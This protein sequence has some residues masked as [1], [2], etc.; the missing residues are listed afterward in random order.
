MKNEKETKEKLLLCAKQEFMEKG[1]NKASLRNICKNAGVT[2]GALYFFFTG[3]EDLFASLVQKPLDM[4]YAVM[5]KHYQE[6]ILQLQN[7]ALGKEDYSE[8]EETANQIIHYLYQYK[9]EFQLI[10]TK[11]QGSCFENSLDR[12]VAITEQHYRIIADKIAETR[13]F[14]KMDNYMIHWMA[15]MHMDVFVHMIT[16]EISEKEAIFHMSLIIKYLTCGW[17]GMLEEAKRR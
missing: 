15:H 16:H 5:M 9:K 6:E 17:N 13:N 12:F 4:L 14:K 1:Y 2:T 11:S 3:K 10:L 7:G 8:D